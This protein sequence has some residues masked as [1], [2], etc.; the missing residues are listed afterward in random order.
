VRIVGSAGES[1]DEKEK[2]KS[3][4]NLEGVMVKVDGVLSTA[5][6]FAA[7]EDRSIFLNH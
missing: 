2:G 3:G 5:G 6:L 1:M 4:G 7:V